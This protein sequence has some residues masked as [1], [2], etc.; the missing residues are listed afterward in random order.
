KT[1]LMLGKIIPFILVG[2]VQMTVILVLGRLLFD[3]PLRGN[4][5]LLYALTFT[6]IVANLAQ[7]LFVSTIASTQAQAMQLSFFFILP[8]VLLSGFMFPRDAMPLPAQW[9][10]MALPLTYYLRV[11]RGILLK[12]VGFSQVWQDSAILAGFA[13]LL[14]SLSVARFRKTIS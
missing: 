2:Y 10:G 11:L 14:L 7:G 9:I 12:G 1:S 3:I 13:V 8:N 6:Y 4:I 5:V